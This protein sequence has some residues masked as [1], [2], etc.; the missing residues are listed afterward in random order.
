MNEKKYFLNSAHY[1]KPWEYLGHV[2]RVYKIF[3][4]EKPTHFISTGSGRTALI[5]YLMAKLLRL[6]IIYIETYSR[7]KNLTLSAKLV[8]LMG[9]IVYTQWP[10]EI[11]N[12][13]YLGP[14]FNS[15]NSKGPVKTGENSYVF[16]SLGTRSEPFTRLVTSVEQLVVNGIIKEKVIIQAGCTPYKSIHMKIFDFCDADKIE[17]LIKNARYIVTQESAGIVNKCLKYGKPFLVMPRDYAF[18]ELPSKHDMEEDLQYKL[19]ELGYTKVVT[20]VEELKVAVQNIDKIKT[21]F[22]YNNAETVNKL[23]AMVHNT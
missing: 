16:V 11:K 9:D 3:Q 15:V 22:V 19:E 10:S 21:G 6:N 12:T 7:V 17:E 8:R 23:N 18:K 4:E 2:K 13:S 20:D 1:K 5:P 14:V